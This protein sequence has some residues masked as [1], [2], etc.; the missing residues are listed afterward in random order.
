MDA[1][2]PLSFGGELLD[3]K[4]EIEITAVEPLLEDIV[5]LL[6]LLLTHY[7]Y[8]LLLAETC[9]HFQVSALVGHNN[10]SKVDSKERSQD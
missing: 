5:V 10:L 9:A 4:S 8:K 1:S 2:S 6:I 7:I 3:G